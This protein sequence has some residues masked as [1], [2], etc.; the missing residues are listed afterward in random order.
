MFCKQFE[1]IYWVSIFCDWYLGM[2]WAVGYK[3]WNLKCIFLDMLSMLIEYLFRMN[4][5]ICS[6]LEFC[7]IIFH[8]LQCIK[9]RNALSSG[10]LKN[11]VMIHQWKNSL[12]ASIEIQLLCIDFNTFCCC[13]KIC[14]N[15]MIIKCM[16]LHSVWK[17]EKNG[18]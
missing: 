5:K 7:F 18:V 3:K 10:M 17:L 15:E 9:Q 2:W 1:N 12:C 16:Y 13:R 6:C 11:A 14:K 8:L 4:F